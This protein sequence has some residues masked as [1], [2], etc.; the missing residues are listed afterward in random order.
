MTGKEE[1]NKKTGEVKAVGDHVPKDLSTVVTNDIVSIGQLKAR[2]QLM[3]EMIELKR[4]FLKNNLCEG[5]ENDYAVIPGC[6]DKKVLLKP[7]AEKLLDW[8]GFYPTFVLASEKE[9]FDLQLF[10]YVYR[11]EVKQKG[12]NILI[13]DC[14]GDASTHESKYR[15]E[16]RF[17]N[18]LPAGID[19]S[20]LKTREVG[21]NKTI[22]YQVFADNPAD[23]RN[24]VR[25]MAQKRALM[26]ATVLATATS[27]LF[28]TEELPGD[29]TPTTGQTAKQ[30]KTDYGT[31]I[32]DK[33]A[34]RLYAIRKSSEI[35]NTEFLGW[36]KTKYGF[37]SDREI[38]YKVYDEIC[39]AVESG[40]L[41]EVEIPAKQENQEK[42]E[43]AKSTPSDPDANLSVDQIKELSGL[44]NNAKIK[45]NQ[46]MEWLGEF[47]QEYAGKNLNN[48][49]A[50]DY[51]EIVDTFKQS[52]SAGVF[53][54]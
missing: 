36:L 27:D 10:S 50:G 2:M 6:G 26:G 43:S 8:H 32:S 49:K 37:K 28:S 23:K 24:T 34:K 21:R 48:I 20:T 31:P 1:L 30:K 15:F 54:D 46:F 42:Q 35:D 47:K 44:I 12:T 45:P 5:I 33:Q 18:Q 16:W 11:C 51:D 40:R 25:K 19:K 22:Q 38:G 41:P 7:G 52:I 3:T 13:A 4:Q 9:D 29:D 14:E 53:N 39:K 17:E